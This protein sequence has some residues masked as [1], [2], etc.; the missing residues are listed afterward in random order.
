M[1]GDDH[2]EGISVFQSRLVSALKKI[3]GLA[4]SGAIPEALGPLNC[5][6]CMDSG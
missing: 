3:G 2:P 5:N 6:Q 1:Q 4:L